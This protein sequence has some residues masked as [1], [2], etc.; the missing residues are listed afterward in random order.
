MN[1]IIELQETSPNFWK[2]RYRG[3]Y[4]TYTIKIE[5]DGRN[6]RNFSCSCP[7]DY[8][9]C[10]HIPI[11]QASI[12]ERIHRNKVKPEKPVF[13]SVVRG[14]SLHDLQ[15]FV[16][17]FG[18][19]NSSFQQAVLLELTPQQKQHGNINYS[20]IIRCAL[21][22]I[23]FDMDDIYDY[24]YDSF[25]IDVLDQWLNKSREY[26]EQDNWKEAI[27]IA[28]ACLE[29]YAEWTRR[30]DV[31]PDGYI[32]EEY[33]YGPFDILE[34]A[35]EAGCLTAEE[36]LAYC[37]KEVG[38]NKY[39]SVTQDLF[40]DL[41][42]NLTQD[43]DPEAYISMQDRLFSSLSDKNSYEAKQIL[44]RKIDFYK[45]RGDAQT[46]QRILEEN[47]QIEDFRQIIVKEMIADNKYKEAKRLINEYIQSKD[48]NNSFNGYHSCWDEYLLEIARKESN[49]KEIRRISRKF[50]DRAFHLKY[51]QLYKSTFSEDEWATEN[52]KLIKHYQKGNNWFI[53]SIADIFVEEKQ[54]AR[55]LAYL[56]KHLRCNILEQYYKHI[57]DEFPEETV[58]LFKQAVDEYMRNTGRDVYEN[59]VKH[60]E[61][62]LN[63]KG[64]EDV[65]KQMIGNYTM[66][67]K[68]R[69]TMIEVFTRFSK[70]RLNFY[71]F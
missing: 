48:T 40:N 3:N 21:E 56:T 42:M 45:Q 18:S 47:L 52:E 22:D 41:V 65:V 30:I 38:K 25:E 15:E 61:S 44:E 54:T 19:H 10:K 23:D 57:A 8:Y 64:G 62:M 12:N 60:F 32:S 27:L 4:G 1:K 59:S 31:D 43:T 63:V 33:L 13:E 37:K 49:T 36:L 26:I 68:T 70:S 11:V 55:L 5:T 50:I 20:E 28:K 2:A 51:Y 17:R 35:Y 69:R 66:Q 29:E 67:Y 14:I 34:K 58:A 7:S 16:I 9:P 39:D 6:T 46:A 71:I 53:S 24:H